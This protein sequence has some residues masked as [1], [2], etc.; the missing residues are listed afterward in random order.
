MCRKRLDSH[1]TSLIL[2]KSKCCSKCFNSLPFT[3]C[4]LSLSAHI[5]LSFNPQIIFRCD[6]LYI[7]DGFNKSVGQEIAKYSGDDPS[8]H[9]YPRPISSSGP[10]LLLRFKSDRNVTRSGFEI[11]VALSRAGKVQNMTCAIG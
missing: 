5:N 10:Y 1:L 3:L 4:L 7:Y 11:S 6:H 9:L 8:G 2:R